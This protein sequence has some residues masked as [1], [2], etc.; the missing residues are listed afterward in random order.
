MGLRTGLVMAVVAVG[1]TAGLVVGLRSDPVAAS[2]KVGGTITRA[3]VLARAQFWVDQHVAYGT[4]FNSNGAV[5]STRSAPDLNGR[6]YRTDCSG[7][8]S[9]AWNLTDAPGTSSYA[10]NNN[11]WVTLT[12]PDNGADAMKPGDAMVG[13]ADHIELFAGWKNDANHRLGAWTY[14]L[15]GPV[16]QDWAKGP[17]PNFMGQVGANSWA[18][19]MAYSKHI[20]YAY[21]V[22]DVVSSHGPVT[23]YNGSP[24]VYAVGTDGR[25][26][27]YVNLDGV[28][29]GPTVVGTGLST[30]S[31]PAV[32]MFDGNLD[33]FAISAGGN[34]FEYYF[35]SGTWHGPVDVGG[36]FATTSSPAANLDNG[37]LEVYAIGVNSHMFESYFTD[38]WHGPYDL[39]IGPLYSRTSSPAVLMYYGTPELYAIAADGH[40]VGSYFAG[41]W[42]GPLDLGRGFTTMT[43]P[44]VQLDD[45]TLE[46][47]G[48][49]GNSH[50]FETYFTDT[51]HGPV[52]IAVG[53]EYSPSATPAVV[54][55]NGLPEVYAVTA[56]G[57]LDGSYFAAGW[58]GPADIGGGYRPGI[59]A[60]AVVDGQLDL[61]HISTAG[62]LVQTYYDAGWRGPVDLATAGATT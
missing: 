6:S 18:T 56:T 27:G 39:P 31:T 43:S 62:H 28:W 15:N 57:H 9:M 34:L 51:W 21:I 42:H 47:Y 58:H 54:I 59:P 17:L 35:L 10:G 55:Y 32:I 52:D 50:L 13:P 24:E 44:A 23:T 40:L 19:I 41:S 20:R 30:M 36:G 5:V 11:R 26:I 29:S 46:I 60:V 2:A 16:D 4:T 61:Y 45:G 53:N 25:L 14:S 7:L 22:D 33:V 48:V 38:G 12:G 49:G 37:V 1:A 3:Q 8:V